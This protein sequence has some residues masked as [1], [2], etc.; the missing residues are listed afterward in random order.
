MKEEKFRLALGKMNQAQLD[1]FIQALFDS[2]L[3]PTAPYPANPVGVPQTGS[4]KL[5]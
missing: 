3:V 5:Q 4:E 1:E 2:G